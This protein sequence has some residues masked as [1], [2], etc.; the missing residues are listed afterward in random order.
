V[1]TGAYVVGSVVLIALVVW[2]TRSLVWAIGVGT[3]A[4]VLLDLVV[5]G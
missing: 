1:L 2:R 3:A 4:A 5:L